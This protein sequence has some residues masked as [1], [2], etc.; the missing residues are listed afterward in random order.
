MTETNLSSPS[1][2]PS[3]DRIVASLVISVLG[4][5]TLMI[6]SKPEWLGMDRSPVVGFV[7]ISVFTVG[8][9]ILCLGGYIGLNHLWGGYQKTILADFGLRIIATGYVVVVFTG[10]ADIFGL[11]THGF[12]DVPFFGPWQA[13]GVQIGQAVILAGFLMLIP[14]QL[15]EAGEKKGP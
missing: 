3:R 9:G 2:Q 6:G 14:Y 7:Q 1:M 12:P 10:M 15:L 4:F 13:V 11:G 8:I 5:I